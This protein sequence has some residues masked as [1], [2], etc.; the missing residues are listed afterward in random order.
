MGTKKVLL[1]MKEWKRLTSKLQECL[2]ANKALNAQIEK[3]NK[4]AEK[5]NDANSKGKEK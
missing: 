5:H 3:Y 2:R 4:F 1:S